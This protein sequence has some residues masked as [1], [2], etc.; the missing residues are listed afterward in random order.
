MRCRKLFGKVRL[1]ATRPSVVISHHR[2]LMRLETDRRSSPD[3][4]GILL[5][6]Y[7]PFA[8]EAI[9]RFVDLLKS[10]S[11][12]YVLVIVENQKMQLPHTVLHDAHIVTGDNSLHEF[13]GWQAGLDYCKRSGLVPQHGILV[14]ANDT[15]CH[16]NKFGP[17]TNWCFVH[18]FKKLLKNPEKVALAGEVHPT[19][20]VFSLDGQPFSQWVS[21]YLYAMTVPLSAKVESLTMPLNLDRFFTG[22][23][24]S[25]KFLMGPLNENLKNHLVNYLFGLR[26]SAKWYAAAPISE[27]NLAK[28]VGKTKS[29][30][31]EMHLS[32]VTIR[33]GGQLVSV[34]DNQF[35]QQARRLERLL[36]RYRQ[37]PSVTK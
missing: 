20:G 16:H 11:K 25:D 15:F 8:L 19:G 14:F 33:L 6:Y 30:L 37:S 18:A 4:V 26:G 23:A 7:R 32:A 28:F 2:M 12:D 5:L 10:V 17:I 36:P 34:F 13:S 22:H 35:V 24:T 9:R 27:Q 31:C 1:E 21:T 29:I 3:T